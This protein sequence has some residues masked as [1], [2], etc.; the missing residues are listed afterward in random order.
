[1]IKKFICLILLL[2]CINCSNTDKDNNT[3]RNEIIIDDPE[4]LYEIA[5]LTFDQQNY[6]LANK[7]FLEISSTN[8]QMINSFLYIASK[9]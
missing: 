2:L 5:K 8:I 1:M 9:L 3:S 6:E 7:Q 4:N